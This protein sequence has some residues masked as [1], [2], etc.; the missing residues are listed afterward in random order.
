MCAIS[1]NNRIITI[2]IDGDDNLDKKQK[3]KRKKSIKVFP[4]MIGQLNA[5]RTSDKPEMPIQMETKAEF[6]LKRDLH[7]TA[8]DFSHRLK[9]DDTKLLSDF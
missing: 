6:D 3:K 5:E 9:E 1:L 8:F 2:D 7:Y 4:N